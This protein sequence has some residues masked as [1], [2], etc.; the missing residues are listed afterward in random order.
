MRHE[1]VS[2][3][4]FRR[5]MVGIAMTL[6]IV[7]GSGCDKL[8]EVELPGRLE[9]SKLDDPSMVPVLQIGMISDFECAFQGYS[10]TSSV[11]TQEYIN[12]VTARAPLLWAQRVESL[13]DVAGYLGCEQVGGA[14]LPLQTA[15]FQAQ[16]LY[17]RAESF[18]T[19]ELPTKEEALGTSAAYGGYS[20]LLLGEGFCEMAM[21]GGPL[22]TREEVFKVAEDLFTKALAHQTND[23]IRH[24]ALVGRARTRLNMGNGAGA[25]A[26]AGLVPEGFA[27]K[28]EG[29][30]A[31]SRRENRQFVNTHQNLEWSV[32]PAYRDL[33]IGGMPDVRV[34]VVDT[35]TLGQDVM[36]PLW[37]Q[38]KYTS[39]SAPV[40]L[41]SW[42]EAQLIIAEVQGGSEAVSAINRL[43]ASVGL[44]PFQGTDPEEIRAQVLEERRRETFLEGHRL[45]DLLRLEIPFPTGKTHKG[46]P[47][48]PVTCIPL[49]TTERSVNPNIS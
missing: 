49:P 34:P 18:S 29:S 6:T 37:L 22:M 43:R 48:G 35:E 5:T 16:E 31:A 25:V 44:P 42:R 20:A 15:R 2:H 26:D 9:S 40:T 10:M 19:T 39:Y 24:M 30:R 47:Y 4:G 33:E 3:R 36:T 1:P 17:A 7:M 28:I 45:G 8:L 21:D 14:Y 11:L 12:A 13:A 32:A 41:A 27:K 23:D 46:Q 38:M